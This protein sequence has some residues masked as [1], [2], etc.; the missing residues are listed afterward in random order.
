MNTLHLISCIGFLTASSFSVELMQTSRYLKQ[1]SIEAFCSSLFIR[2][3]APLA[4]FDLLVA[5]YTSGLELRKND[6]CA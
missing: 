5:V 4:F 1:S 2:I 6:R 3:A